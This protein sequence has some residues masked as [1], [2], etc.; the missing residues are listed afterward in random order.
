MQPFNSILLVDDDKATIFLSQALLTYVHA[1]KEIAIAEDGII[2]CELLKKGHCPDIIF[3]DIRMPRMDGFE[4]LESL[5]K[6][7]VCKNAKIVML[8]SSVMLEEKQ[9]AFAYKKVIE[10]FEK[11]L[12][13]ELIMKVINDCHSGGTTKLYPD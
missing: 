7:D 12:T 4:F 11:P 1:A 9:K 6:M 2:A 13:E 10:Y 5:E 8:S 3:L